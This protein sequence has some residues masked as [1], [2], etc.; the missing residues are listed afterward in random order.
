MGKK[1]PAK[2][3]LKIIESIIDGKAD[4]SPW[5]PFDDIDTIPVD[6]FNIS[7][8]QETF[9]K[10]FIARFYDHIHF[11]ESRQTEKGGIDQLPA[12]ALAA[13]NKIISKLI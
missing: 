3:T 13:L 6:G 4:L 11:I 8:E 5:E 12:D 9:R 7:F 2:L 10:E 1:I